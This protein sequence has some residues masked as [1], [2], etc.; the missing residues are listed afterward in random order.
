MI[1]WPLY[2]SLIV[3]TFIFPVYF[4][5][6]RRTIRGNI[7]HKH[8]YLELYTNSRKHWPKKNIFEIKSSIFRLFYW[9]KLQKL[10]YWPTLSWKGPSL[11]FSQFVC[12]LPRDIHIEYSK[13]FKW[14]SCFYGFGQSRPFWAALELL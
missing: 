1:P 6:T 10:T 4:Y 7:I 11:V 5:N 13:Q 8:I 14:N 2:N 9:S 3:N 12:V